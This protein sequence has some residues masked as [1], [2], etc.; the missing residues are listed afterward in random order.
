MRPPLFSRR[1]IVTGV[2]CATTL[3]H[4]L[5]ATN[6]NQNSSQNKG[7]SNQS[8]PHLQTSRIHAS[9]RKSAYFVGL[10]CAGLANRVEI[11]PPRL[12]ATLKFPQISRIL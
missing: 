11:S 6:P 5:R 3:R 7:R 2:R 12:V 9:A 10:V 1:Q 8:H 4:D